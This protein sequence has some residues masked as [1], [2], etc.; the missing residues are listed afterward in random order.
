MHIVRLVLIT[1][2]CWSLVWFLCREIRSG[3]RSGEIAYTRYRW[4]C[5]RNSNPVGFWLLV[6]L[7]ACFASLASYSW[8]YAVT[9]SL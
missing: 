1:L 6:L 4:L 5:R 3:V 8:W 2:I 9:Q 7:F